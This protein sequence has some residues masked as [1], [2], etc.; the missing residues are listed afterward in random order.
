MCLVTQ[1]RRRGTADGS[2][3]GRSI[4]TAIG[5]SD[6]RSVI[7]RAVPRLPPSTKTP[8]QESPASAFFFGTSDL[9][10][11]FTT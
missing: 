3:A 2:H 4:A 10:S 11:Q 5:G 8:R 9:E 7:L 6:L 1:V